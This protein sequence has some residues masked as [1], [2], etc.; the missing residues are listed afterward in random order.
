MKIYVHINHIVTKYLKSAISKMEGRKSSDLSREKL[1][2]EL[3]AKLDDK[4][5]SV[6]EEMLV[7][8]FGR[9]KLQFLEE[10]VSCK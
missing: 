4:I 2:L 5:V 10:V 1:Y 9:L 7:F 8:V 3:K 6:G